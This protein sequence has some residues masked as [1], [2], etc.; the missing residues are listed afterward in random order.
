MWRT[1]VVTGA[2][3]A[4]CWANQLPADDKPEGVATI[5]VR[6]AERWRGG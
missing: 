2:F 6:G 3:A 4:V 5:T 1:I